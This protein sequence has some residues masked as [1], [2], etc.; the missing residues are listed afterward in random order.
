MDTRKLL[1]L[2][3]PVD[4]SSSSIYSGADHKIESFEMARQLDS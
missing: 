4:G 3:Y 2:F 1:A